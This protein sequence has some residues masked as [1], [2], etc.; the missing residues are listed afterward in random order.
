MVN[1]PKKHHYVPRSVLRNFSIG[2]EQRSVFVFDKNSGR[3]FASA[4]GDAAAERDFYRVDL[5]E[6]HINFEPLFQDLDDRLA[7][8]VAKL[9][10]RPSLRA[11]DRADRYDLAVVTAC[12]LLRTKLQRTSSMEVARQLSQRLEESGVGPPEETLDEQQARLGSLRR[13][14]ALEEIAAVLAGKD[15]VLVKTSS[16]VLWTSD[17]PV[18]F[19]NTF[20]YGRPALA[21]PGVEVY[22]PIAPGLCLAFLCRSLG[23]ILA[24]SLDPEHPRPATGTPLMPR[25]LASIRE[26]VPLDGDDNYSNYLNELQIRYSSRFLYSSRDDFGL[27]TEVLT[28][29]P[30]LR[31][32]RTRVTVGKMGTWLPPNPDMPS[33]TWLV[34]ESGYRHHILPV[35]LIEDDSWAFAFTTTDETKLMLMERDSPFESVTLYTDGHALQMIRGVVFQYLERNGLRYVRVQHADPQ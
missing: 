3:S 17:N 11:L 28:S 23:E 26:G 33:G 19:C 15:L 13:L 16:P 9:T 34:V 20:P 7:S 30:S 2:G 29:N 27:A 25:L 12:Q 10:T 32:V 1:E 31:E 21:A 14:L 8:L 35:T 4:I 18:V 6:R 24:E 5:G 22:H